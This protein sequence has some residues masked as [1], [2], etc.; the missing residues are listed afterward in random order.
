MLTFGLITLPL[1]A[2]TSQALD[3][4][5]VLSACAAPVCPTCYRS[6]F[7]VTFST[8]NTELEN[9]TLP[10]CVVVFSPAKS[11]QTG[12]R[13]TGSD[14][15]VFLMS[16]SSTVLLCFQWGPEWFWVAL[17]LSPRTCTGRNHHV[18]SWEQ[19]KEGNCTKNSHSHFR[20]STDHL[21]QTRDVFC[22]LGGV[23]TWEGHPDPHHLWPGLAA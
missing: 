2:W 13:S 16:Y 22:A 11:V 21:E 9:L 10:R 5:S 1:P 23:I 20:R 3:N 7:S 17:L 6:I 18:P 14:M 8:K 4:P 12:S 15:C 19:C